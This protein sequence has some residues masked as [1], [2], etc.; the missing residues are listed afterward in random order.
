MIDAVVTQYSTE[1]LNWKQLEA[2]RRSAKGTPSEFS[3]FF[4]LFFALFRLAAVYTSAAYACKQTSTSAQIMLHGVSLSE[5]RDITQQLSA[6]AAV[7][8]ISKG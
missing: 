1:C 5:S 2:K 8:K 6:N 3:P 4:A 7:R